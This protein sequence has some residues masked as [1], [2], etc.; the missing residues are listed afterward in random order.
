MK[1]QFK[2]LSILLILATVS[3]FCIT[4]TACGSDDEPNSSL[5]GYWM[6]NPHEGWDGYEFC[7][8]LHFTGS[9]TVVY[10]SYLA[11]GKYW[12]NAV[13]G[14][15]SFPGQSGWYSQSGGD[16]TYNYTKD[17]N[18]LY[19]VTSNLDDAKILNLSNFHKVN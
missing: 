14:S 3:L 4:L 15:K 16:V 10:Y 7:E 13:G 6:T 19:L 2:N 5:S 1:K 18:K 9:S 17:G 11:N 12:S 8:G